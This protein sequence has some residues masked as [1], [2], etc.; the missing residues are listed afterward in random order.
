MSVSGLD[1]P[2]RP[3]PRLLRMILAALLLAL[4]VT[5]LHAQEVV[6]PV[7]ASAL[8]GPEGEAAA[9]TVRHIPVPEGEVL[10]IGGMA[11]MA[12]GRLALSTRR[13]R[14]WMVDDPLGDAP[15][16][17]I[18]AEGL[19]EGLGLATIDVPAEGGGTRQA[20]YVLQ[21]GELTELRD[22]DGDGRAERWLTVSDDWGLSGHYHEFAFGLPW[23]GDRFALS[24]N[25]S[26]PSPE[27]WLGKSTVPWRGWALTVDPL[28][29]ETTPIASG[30]RSPAGFGSNRAGELFITDNQGDWMPT[31]PIFH[32]QPGRWYGHPAS[33][34]WT[35]DYQRNRV[36]PSHLE[37][38]DRRRAD[39]AVWVPY[40]WSRSAGDLLELTDDRFGPFE[41]QY[42]LAEVTNGRLLRVM[43]ERVRGEYQGAVIPLRDGV[44]A[45]LRLLRAPD[46]GVLA[47]LTNRGW[48]GLAPADGLAHIAFTGETPFEI[49]DVHLLQDGFAL[50]F[51]RPLADDVTVAPADVSLVQYDYDS[52][53]EYG[54]PERHMT[55]VPVTAVELDDDRLGLTLRTAGLTPA[56]VARVTLTGLRDIDGRPLLH[57]EF[58]YTINQLPE[59]PATDAHVVK[60]VEPP[61]PKEAG[62]EGWLRLS[63]GDALDAWQ[64]EGWA[65]V[66]AEL[67]AADP[68]T[69][70]IRPG[71]NALVNVQ[72]GPA[73]DYVS[74]WDLGSGR[75][76]VEFMLPQGGRSEVLVQGRYGIVLSDDTR[77]L[78][79]GRPATGA[80][81]AAADGSRPALPPAHDAYAGAGAW[82]ELDIHFTAPTVADDGTQL[83][84]AVLDEVRLDQ[85]VLH[86]DVVLDGPTVGG[87][88]GAV[89]AGPLVIR[90][91]DG[92]VALRTL[93]ASPSTR[94]AGDGWVPLLRGDDLGAWRVDPAGPA[95]PDD[96][97]WELE[98]G[99]LLGFGPLNHLYAPRDDYGDVILRCQARLG[100]E[101]AGAVIL[102]AG[103][104]PGEPEGYAVRLDTG[105]ADPRKSGSI[106]GGPAVR[107]QLIP[108]GT[109]FDLEVHCTDT[110]EGT[111]LAV[112]INGALVNESV[113]PDRRAG[114]GSLAFQQRPSSGLVRFRDVVVREP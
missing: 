26:F 23:L 96:G 27:W 107:V 68:S 1:R 66:D 58:A 86:E 84:P 89:A 25:V 93:E 87:L 69:F 52:W 32:I 7:D 100:A 8:A 90:G 21:R 62:Q 46:G 105:T 63:Y 43:L 83:T 29:G 20:L 51:T 14:V 18:F 45:A 49:R 78:P 6:A 74:R 104:G 54:S 40:K 28:T 64:S 53:W 82:H 44:G 36:I 103:F 67:N 31:G 71:V 10:E 114:R 110:P 91:T 2:R 47:G 97:G 95:D 33:L 24:L 77:G 5:P 102:R 98:D 56:M 109:W 99:E 42:V 30:L 12:D 4:S 15:S 9:W 57:D 38:P 80:I 73:S 94:P 39:A 61:P 60:V 48:G 35:E 13:G 50:S 113:D 72:H 88:P 19:H 55:D 76:H 3:S 22:E 85:V 59:G 81:A 75:Y 17:S 111:R 108:P 41:G 101:A 92:P 34:R 106:V 79:E 112:W 65:L 11:W 70:A 16:F 37:P